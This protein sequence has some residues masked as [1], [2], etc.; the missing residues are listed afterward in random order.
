MNKLKHI[1]K[2]DFENKL[3]RSLQF[4]CDKLIDNK[5]NKRKSKK[6]FKVVTLSLVACVLFTFVILPA[7][8]LAIMM[9]KIDENGKLLNKNYTINEVKLV[10]SSSFKKLNEVVY[11]SISEENN[12]DVDEKYIEA[13]K[14]F[15]S[16]SKLFSSEIDG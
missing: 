10:E 4:D 3:G 5:P 9:V 12:L 15:S 13:V 1:V 6:I 16:T 14:E 2:E 11:P 7:S 8:I